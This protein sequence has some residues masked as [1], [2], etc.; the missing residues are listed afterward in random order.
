[1]PHI[2]EK[3]DFCSEVFVVHDNK[4]ILR[5]HDKHKIWLSVGGHIEL[6]EDPN[7][8]A[9]REVKEEIGLT[10]RLHGFKEEY[11]QK[12]YKLLVPPEYMLRF[13]ISETHEHVV[14]VYFATSTTDILNIPNV[15]ENKD[16][17]CKWFTREELEDPKYKITPNVKFYA[18]K[19]LE[20]LGEK[21]IIK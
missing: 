1:M 18:K 14:L 6:D 20:K 9:V 13:P 16:A 11:D 8:A 5:F 21:R 4:V 17:P 2:H 7:E 10:I 19:A 12:N 3:I 15:E